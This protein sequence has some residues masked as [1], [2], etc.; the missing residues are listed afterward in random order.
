MSNKLSDYAVQINDTIN[1]NALEVEEVIVKKIATILR[2]LRAYY[3]KKA[4][5]A[6]YKKATGTISE[7]KPERDKDAV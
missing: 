4:F 2:D 7:D 1:D 5:E 6:G 3:T